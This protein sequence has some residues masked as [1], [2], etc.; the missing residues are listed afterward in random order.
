MFETAEFVHQE[1]AM[2]TQ[3]APADTS[4]ATSP[5]TPPTAAPAPPSWAWRRGALI[6]AGAAQLITISALNSADPLAVTWWSLLLAIAPAPLAAA[7]AFAPAPLNRLGAVTALL[8]LVAG[9]AGGIVHI[10]LFFVP[11]LVV[12]AVGTVLLWREQS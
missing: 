3:N 12:L 6:L 4:P 1:P 10:G 5:T 11:A 8:V 7:A 2:T 9:I